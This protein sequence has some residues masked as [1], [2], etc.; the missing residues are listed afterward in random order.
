MSK[1]KHLHLLSAA[2]L[3]CWHGV[4]A[5]KTICS[6]RKKQVYKKKQNW[7]KRLKYSIQWIVYHA[8]KSHVYTANWQTQIPLRIQP[9]TANVSPLLTDTNLP[10]NISTP[11]Y[12]PRRP[13]FDMSVLTRYERKKCAV[14]KRH[15]LSLFTQFVFT[16]NC[17]STFVIFLKK[18]SF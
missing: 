18:T 12:K 4:R 10:Q 5:K 1:Y 6:I 3:C 15:F 14:I 2:D 16:K 9:P 13:K 8:V 11:K 17:G 7:R